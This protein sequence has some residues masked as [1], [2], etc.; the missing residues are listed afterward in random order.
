M[1][2]ESDERRGQLPRPELAK[3]ASRARSAQLSDD[4]VSGAAL[5]RP[6]SAPPEEHDHGEDPG[7]LLCRDKRPACERVGTP[8]GR[9]F[10]RGNVRAETIDAFSSRVAPRTPP[11]LTGESD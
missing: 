2:C 4:R 3:T 10:S 11:A 1:S 6:S 5:G 9:A 7:V 8:S